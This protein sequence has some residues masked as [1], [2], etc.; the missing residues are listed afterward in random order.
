MNQTV[1]MKRA[2][3]P[4]EVK[5]KAYTPFI[6]TN[7]KESAFPAIIMEYTIKNRGE[8]RIE[9]ELFGWLQ[10]TA[11]LFAANENKGKQL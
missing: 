7:Y 10:N 5:L 1:E 11:N 8:E 4:L 2:T 3:I 6:P 9:A